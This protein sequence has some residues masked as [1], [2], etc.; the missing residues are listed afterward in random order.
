MH[1]QKRFRDPHPGYSRTDH[2]AETV[3]L[4]DEA[5]DDGA[6][7]D[8]SEVRAGLARRMASD[9][10]PEQAAERNDA[11]VAAAQQAARK[12]A[13]AQVLEHEPRPVP[14]APSCLQRLARRI[15]G[16]LR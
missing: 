4:V 8:L 6:D 15:R 7:E 5:M 11:V 1:D 16:W 9:A 2:K 13:A 3:A 12:R 10:E 14:R